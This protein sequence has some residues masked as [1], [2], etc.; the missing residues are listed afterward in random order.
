MVL[1][2]HIKDPCDFMIQRVCYMEQLQNMMNIINIYCDS[3]ENVH[4]LLYDVKSGMLLFC[5]PCRR[6]ERSFSL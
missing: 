5:N 1:V 6:Y 4:D 2:T 3:T